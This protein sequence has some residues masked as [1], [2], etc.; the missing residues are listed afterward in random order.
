M[1]TDSMEG[2]GLETED[3]LD[4]FVEWSSSETG[5]VGVKGRSVSGH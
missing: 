5:R 4:I 3:L 1:P 2:G